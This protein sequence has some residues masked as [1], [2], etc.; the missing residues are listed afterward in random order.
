MR[1]PSVLTV[2]QLNTYVKFLLDGDERL[3]CVYVTGE[4]SNFTDHYRSGHLY[5]SLKDAKCTVKA[6]MFAT[7]ARRLRFRP[8][9]GMKV[10]VR[11]RLSAYEVSGQYQLYVDDMQPAG[12]GARAVA[13]EQLKEKLRLEGLF[14]PARKK[15]LPRFPMTIGI[16]TSPTG[17]AVHDMLTI[18]ARR[19]PLA[20]VLFCPVS[21]QGQEAPAQL[22]RA[23]EM[24][25]Q[26]PEVEVILFGRGGG[27]AEDLSAFDEESVVRAVANSKIPVVSAVGHETDVALTDFAAD[28]R[29]P[30]PSAA[31]ELAVPDAAD[32]SAELRATRE[33]L[34][35]SMQDLL[36]DSR[37]HLDLLTQSLQRACA[38]PVE[39]RR[40]ELAM[41]AGRLQDLNPLRVLARGYSMTID[42]ENTVVQ[43]IRQVAVGDRVR[44]RL[45]DGSLLCRVEEKEAAQ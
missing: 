2:T 7:A 16:I 43:G 23:L 36:N 31:A 26:I 4:V 14:D 18:L 38:V 21:V 17:A 20:K 30:T 42:T 25:N 22:V 37:M 19:W 9:D 35:S 29:A 44:V 12:A 15:P 8:A 41:L 13:L 10:L 39:K 34:D 6:V 1:Q 33:L 24:L 28:L 40:A 5:F 3:H 32:L 45:Q 11:G 27:S